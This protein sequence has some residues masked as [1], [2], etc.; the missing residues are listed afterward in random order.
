[1]ADTDNK[2]QVNVD[3]S[4]FPELYAAFESLVEEL[5]TDKSKLIRQLV[6]ERVELNQHVGKIKTRVSRGIRQVART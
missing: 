2:M 3:F 1:M 5:D 4:K 6:R